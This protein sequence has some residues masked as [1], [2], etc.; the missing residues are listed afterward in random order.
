M[1]WITDLE[2]DFA[3]EFDGGPRIVTLATLAGDR[4]DARSVVVRDF[5]PDGSVLFTSDSRSEKNDQIRASPHAAIVIWLPKLKRQYRIHGSV[6]I[7]DASNPVLTKHWE[8]LSN[9]SRETF[10]WPP[11]GS[12]FV[13]ASDCSTA[14]PADVTIPA[15][16]SV[17][18]LHPTQVDALDLNGRPH[19]RARWAHVGAGWSAD[20]IN[21]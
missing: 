7:L 16:F 14:T 21:A 15:S 11:P 8:K 18:I 19:L 17:L 4:P 1:N 9:A 20:R 2:T 12:P 5:L 10:F 6:E 3:K 13:G